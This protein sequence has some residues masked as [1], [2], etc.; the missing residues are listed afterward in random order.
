MS[1]VLSAAKMFKWQKEIVFFEVAKTGQSPNYLL[2]STISLFFLYHH[3]ALHFIISTETPP[4]RLFLFSLSAIT[5]AIT[6][7]GFVVSPSQAG[8]WCSEERSANRTGFFSSDILS[9]NS[10]QIQSKV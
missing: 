3:C 10:W 4:Q 9:S 5:E 1:F 8:Y 6:G 2:F 7:K